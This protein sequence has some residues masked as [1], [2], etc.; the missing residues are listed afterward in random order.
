MGKNC[1]S[2]I[3]FC[4]CCL[5]VRYSSVNTALS[6]H[7]DNEEILDESLPIVITSVG[8][9]RTLQFWDADSES[10][11]TSCSWKQA[12]RASCGIK[13]CTVHNQT[14]QPNTVKPRYALSFRKIKSLYAVPQKSESDATSIQASSPRPNHLKPLPSSF[15]VHPD[16]AS[17]VTQSA[18]NNHVSNKLWIN[19]SLLVIQW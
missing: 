8:P 6:L 14:P 9:A 10:K 15:L 18:R 7:Q 17:P 3:S 1:N 12:A 5:L 4:P 11:G 13:C 16:R 19:T 2:A